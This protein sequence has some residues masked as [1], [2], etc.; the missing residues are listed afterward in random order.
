MHQLIGRGV[1]ATL[2]II[3][4]APAGKPKLRARLQ[5]LAEE[6]GLSGAIEWCG[7]CHDVPDRL[8]SLDLV[9]VPSIYPAP[10]RLSRA[11]TR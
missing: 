1:P 10:R 5:R 7:T 8:A 4:D 11:R 2:S 9:I 3:G 6:L